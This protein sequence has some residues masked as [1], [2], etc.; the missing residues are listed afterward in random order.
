MRER[1]LGG[2]IAFWV[3]LL[4]VILYFAAKAAMSYWVGIQFDTF[5]S[6]FYETI[7]HPFEIK[8]AEQTAAFCVIALVGWMVLL[9]S[10][11]VNYGKYMR[12]RE[13]GS[14]EWGSFGYF[15]K[16]Y[17]QKDNLILSQNMWMGLD[18]YKH[19]RNLNVLLI[20]GS[21]SGKTRGYVLPNLMQGNMNYVVTD[22]KGEI[23]RSTGEML[24]KMGYKVR[25][26][27]LKD[28]ENS[29]RFNPL[30]Y[31]KN[32][33]DIMRIAND[34]IKNTTD[35]NAQ[36]GDQFWVDAP[37]VLMQAFL[38]YLWHEA[39]AHEQHFGM[40]PTLLRYMIIKE[41][42]E[43]YVSP[44]DK[45]FAE[46][47][48]RDPEHVAVQSWKL[49]RNSPAKTLKSIKVSMVARVNKFLEQKVVDLLSEDEL[50]LRSLGGEEKTAIFC[51]IP[52]NDST[53]NFIAKMLYTQILKELYYSADQ[54]DSGKLTRPVSLIMDEFANLAIAD[55]FDLI[56]ATNRSRGISISIVIQNLSQLKDLFKDKWENIV[57]NCNTMIYLGGSEQATREYVSKALG[58]ATINYQTITKSSQNTS[59]NINI[60]G[61]ELMTEEEIRTMRYDKCLVLISGEKPVL[62]KKYDLMKHKKIK[63]TQQGGAEAFRFAPERIESYEDWQKANNRLRIIDLTKEILQ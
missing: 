18:F 44:L 33:L 25:V 7:K 17:K 12:G 52:D 20:G 36:K 61:R 40:I 57:G 8:A 5:E 39:P 58:K 15:K 21:G 6:R 10:Y 31:A 27:N 1:K 43:N 37:L 48:E 49:I 55:D 63:L 32:N 26:L 42:D 51:V 14:A 2:L 54:N 56:L 16:F 35:K 47:E 4:G 13:H 3:V 19:K 28:I 11:M 59:T 60:I 62:D 22:P 41:D 45:L 38:F 46:L 29:N 30:A 24:K 23:L 50:D 34:Y 9:A 53:F